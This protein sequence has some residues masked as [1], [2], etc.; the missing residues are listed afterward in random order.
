MRE[1][2]TVP[3]AGRVAAIAASQLSSERMAL[4]GAIIAR[5]SPEVRGAA[6][7]VADGLP[8][9][10]FDPVLGEAL[11]SLGERAGSILG[12][13]D[14]WPPAFARVFELS[15]VARHFADSQRLPLWEFPD[16]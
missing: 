11:R 13:K 5:V 16:K 8:A 9:R 6:R 4:L 3:M 2:E 10:L 12:V 1:I 7:A 15:P 14:V